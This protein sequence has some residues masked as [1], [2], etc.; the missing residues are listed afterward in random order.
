[1]ANAAKRAQVDNLTG[2][3]T[4]NPH[5]A[6]I[7]YEKTTHQALESLRRELRKSG[8]RLTIIKNALLEKAVNKLSQDKKELREFR[9]SV[10]PLKNNTALLTL[11]DDYVAG[12]SRSEEHTSELQSQSNLVC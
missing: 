12:L 5:F 4:Q 8:A 11:G 9:Q 2:V 6:L 7:R 1:M 3:L 10:F